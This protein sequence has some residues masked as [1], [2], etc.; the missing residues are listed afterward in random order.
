[1][2]PDFV[3]VSYIRTDPETLFKALMDPAFTKQYFFGVQYD[4]DWKAGSKIHNTDGAGRRSLWGSVVRV[5][6]P[7]LLSYTFDGPAHGTEA[8][9]PTLATFE[10]QPHGDGVRLYLTHSQLEAQDW[11]A[12]KDT[13]HGLN[14]GWPAI[15]SSL[16][17]LLETGKALTF[18][19]MDG[20][21]EYI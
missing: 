5:E 20:K 11:D 15:L 18:N 14:N 8:G 6:P 13:F 19:P 1:M 9:R 21:G 12:R 3:Y 7:K 4:T 17:S 10:I 16:K 2:A